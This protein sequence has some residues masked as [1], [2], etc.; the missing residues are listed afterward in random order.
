MLVVEG[1]HSPVQYYKLRKFAG[2][3]KWINGG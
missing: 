1:K 3:I 2:G